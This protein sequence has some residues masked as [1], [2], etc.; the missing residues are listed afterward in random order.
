MTHAEL[1]EFKEVGR[2]KVSWIEK[3]N[4]LS[5]ASLKRAIVKKACVL[6][7][8]LDFTYDE[9]KNEGFISAGFRSI[10]TF[11]KAIILLDG[12]EHKER[13]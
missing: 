4:K 7:R 3:I 5:H 9:E 10:G 11:K 2:G 1:I 13:P 8:D 12:K 6:S